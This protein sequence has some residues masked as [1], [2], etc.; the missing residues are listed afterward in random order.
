MR[1]QDNH[2]PDRRPLE[3]RNRVLGALSSMRHGASI[4]QAARENGVSVRTMKKYAGS[5]LAQDRPGGRIRVTES[6]RLV[7]HLQIPGTHGPKALNARGSKI[8]SE[9][10]KYKAD[11]NRAL[12][13]D[14]DALDKW[15]RKKIAGVELVTDVDVLADLADKGQL[16]YAL[17]RAAVGGRK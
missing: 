15:R 7:R 6:D 17:Y 14:E 2:T 5:A 10:A 13:G 8:A 4:S 3:T 9:V 1:K 12:S 11:V 16:P